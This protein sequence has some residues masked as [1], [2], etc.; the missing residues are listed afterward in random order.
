[1]KSQAFPLLFLLLAGC[2]TPIRSTVDGYGEVPITRGDP[3]Y[4]DRDSLPLAEKPISDACRD[5]A[6]SAGLRVSDKPCAECKRVEVR[7]RL[8]G[9]SQ[10]VRSSPGFGTSVGMVGGSTAFGLGFGGGDTESHPESERV[11]DIGIFADSKKPVRTITARSVGR[12]NSISAVASEMCAAAFQDYPANLKGK[13]YAIK[14]VD[15][16]EGQ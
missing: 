6:R 12:E 5:A 8:A 16:G 2:A 14:P 13:V 4:F 9:T 3:L 10:A 1:M 11:I 15:P 7:A